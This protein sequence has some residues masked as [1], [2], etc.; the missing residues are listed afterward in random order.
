MLELEKKKKCVQ[1]EGKKEV[2]E[3]SNV[4]TVRKEDVE[5]VRERE[6]VGWFKGR[7]RC[8]IGEKVACV[9]GEK[10]RVIRDN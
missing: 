8:R 2:Q 6:N 9:E 7:V 1:R 3:V 4:G 5:R 10:G